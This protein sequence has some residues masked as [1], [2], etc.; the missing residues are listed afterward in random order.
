V[1]ISIR[2]TE[3]DVTSLTSSGEE[4]SA[5]AADIGP[6]PILKTRSIKQYLKQYSEPMVDSPQPAEETTK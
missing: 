1:G 4:E 3:E 5:F 6:P 2:E